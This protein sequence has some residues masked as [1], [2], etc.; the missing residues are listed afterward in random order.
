M[1]AKQKQLFLQKSRLCIDLKLYH[2][3]TIAVLEINNSL[4]LFTLHLPFTFIVEV[5]KDFTSAAVIT[6]RKID[7]VLPR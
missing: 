4:F 2:I 5:L 3:F 1:K 6:S 7:F